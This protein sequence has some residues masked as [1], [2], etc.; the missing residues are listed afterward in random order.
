MLSPMEGEELI[1]L[2]SSL[3]GY[4][5]YTSDCGSS[6]GQFSSTSIAH[7]QAHSFDETNQAANSEEK[8]VRVHA[9]FSRIQV[10]LNE[11]YSRMV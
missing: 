9:D 5:S 8:G 4:G 10:M 2:L 11:D 7:I 1:F 6:N 3:R